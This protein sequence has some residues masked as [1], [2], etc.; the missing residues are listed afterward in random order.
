MTITTVYTNDL[1]DPL[2]QETSAI[3]SQFGSTSAR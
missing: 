2:L 1:T 3:A